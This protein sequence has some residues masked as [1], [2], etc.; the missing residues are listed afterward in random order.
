VTLDITQ[1]VAVVEHTLD[2]HE[3]V[4]LAVAEQVTLQA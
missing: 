2:Q 1:A 3:Q 4:V